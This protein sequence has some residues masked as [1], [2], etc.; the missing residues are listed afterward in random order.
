MKKIKII[1]LSIIA[2][3][4]LFVAFFATNQA[5]ATNRAMAIALNNIEAMANDESVKTKECY[6]QESPVGVDR[7]EYVWYH[8]CPRSNSSTEMYKCESMDSYGVKGEKD[9]CLDE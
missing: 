7:N 5:E 4:L 1:F 8:G 2:T 6:T 9:R 3:S